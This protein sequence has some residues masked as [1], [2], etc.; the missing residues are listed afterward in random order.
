MKKQLIIVGG[1]LL[2]LAG[3]FTARQFSNISSSNN[4]T[5]FLV[6]NNLNDEE[7]LT[8]VE[9]DEEIDHELDDLAIAYE[10]IDNPQFIFVDVQ[11]E[12]YAPGVFEV[13]ADVR[14]GYLINLA[15][16]LTRYANTRSLNQA[17]RV[18]DEMVIFVAHIDDEVIVIDQS[19]AGGNTQATSA[20]DDG[21]ISLSR[22]TSTELQSLPGIGPALSANIVAYRESHG[23]FS[24]V[25][26][27]VNVPGI[28]VRLLE[29]VREFVK[30]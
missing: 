13:P 25:D 12:V 28:G 21:L 20:E 29:N 17:S 24:T 5:P 23:D 2:L 22:A 1:I 16:G 8:G 30:P 7:G 4:G 26:E 10:E 19:N 27:L 18:H 14:V 6:S 15:G 11:G 3:I 9:E